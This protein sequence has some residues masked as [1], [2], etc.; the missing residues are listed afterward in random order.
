MLTGID[1]YGD[2]VFNPLQIPQFLSEW[3]DVISNA[4]IDEGSA[5]FGNRRVGPS[6]LQ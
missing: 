4:R 6:M 3:G 2:T 1:L 5:G